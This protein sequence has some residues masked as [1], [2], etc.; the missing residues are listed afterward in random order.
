MIRGMSCPFFFI[1]F[2]PHHTPREGQL[3]G[4]DYLMSF[5]AECE[6]KLEPEEVL[7]GHRLCLACRTDHE[8]FRLKWARRC[9]RC[10][11]CG[12]VLRRGFCR[13]CYWRQHKRSRF[14]EPMDPDLQ[15][16]KYKKK[17]A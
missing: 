12:N 5:C 6:V 11:Q 16:L 8:L 13:V 1:Y 3:S 15:A 17:R 4:S 2:F 14:Y 7:A 9:R 10:A